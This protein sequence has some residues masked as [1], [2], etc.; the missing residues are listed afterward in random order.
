MI[1]S[2]DHSLHFRS[3]FKL[4]TRED[5]ILVWN[6]VTRTVRD[7]IG[8]RIP[9]T[10]KDPTFGQ[11]W[12]FMGGEWRSK[13][14]NRVRVKTERFD[15]VHSPEL[16]QYWSSRFEHPCSDVTARQW[17]TDVGVTVTSDGNLLFSLATIHWLPPGY[18]GQPENPVPSAPSIVARILSSNKWTCLAGSERLGANPFLV[19]D[20]AAQGLVDRLSCSERACP[21]VYIAKD[22]F[23]GTYLVDPYSLSKVLAG[24]ASVYMAESS[25]ADKEIESLVPQGFR[26]WNGMVR[27]YQPDLNFASDADARRHRYFRKEEIESIG[28]KGVEELLVRGIVRRSSAPTFVGVTTLED[29]VQRK[30]AAHIQQLRQNVESKKDAE[31]WSKLLEQDNERLGTEIKRKEEE[32]KYWQSNA[33]L[34]DTLEDEVGR[35]KFELARAVERA[36]KSD[37]IASALA[38][39][40]TV[41]HDLQALPNSVPEVVDLIQKLFPDRIFFTDRAK[42]SAKESSLNNFRIAWECLRA[43]ATVLHDLHFQ[44]KL[45]LREIASQFKNS[46]GFELAVG[47]S[48]TTKANKKLAGQ[49]KDIY[50]GQVID[51]ST[52]VKHGTSAG[53]MLRVHYWPYGNEQKLIIGHCGDHLDTVKTN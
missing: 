47:E 14:A 46:T 11:K 5:S 37:S 15:G 34:V 9:E 49:R 17:R 52:H 30:Q 44:K 21:I 24:T 28:H 1:A 38:V 40:A 7:W 23:E 20:G 45:Q 35:L 12:F 19:R 13:R 4:E 48:E 51:I 41:I 29:V 50:K 27:V 6:D 16:P 22:F 33:E 31:A 25:W 39:R 43:M 42:K 32:L 18:I 36:Q 26:C 8:V 10:K 3:S 2:L 53:N